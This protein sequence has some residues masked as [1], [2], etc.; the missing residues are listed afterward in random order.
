MIT[1]L[2]AL[3]VLAVGRAHES[4]VQ[5]PLQGPHDGLWYNALPGDGGTQVPARGFILYSLLAEHF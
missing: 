1:A 4:H 3:A 5:S 2:V